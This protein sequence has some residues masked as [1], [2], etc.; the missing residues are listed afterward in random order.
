MTLLCPCCFL[1]Q[2]SG[3]SAIVIQTLHGLRD[4]PPSLVLVLLCFSGCFLTEVVS[5]YVVTGVLTPII[6][7][8]AVATRVHPLYFLM[9][10]KASCLFAFML[11]IATGA[12]AILCDMGRLRTIDMMKMG[13]LM[14]VCCVLVHLAAVH[15]IGALVFDLNNFPSW[16]DRD[17]GMGPDANVTA[18]NVSC[19]ETVT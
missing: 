14:N 10:V 6:S 19:P 1:F 12:N 15:T 13:F 18:Q 17:F 5:T 2:R 8:L 4:L 9:P 16:A 3:L 7:E 11:P